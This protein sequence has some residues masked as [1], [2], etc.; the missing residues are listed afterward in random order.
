MN[1]IDDRIFRHQPQQLCEELEGTQNV[2]AASGS[3]DGDDGDGDDDV[4]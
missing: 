4:G 3:D 2:A 1:V